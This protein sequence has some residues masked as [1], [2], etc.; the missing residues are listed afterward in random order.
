MILFGGTNQ[1]DRRSDAH[2]ICA[3][4]PALFMVEESAAS[5]IRWKEA[6]SSIAGIGRGDGCCSHACVITGRRRP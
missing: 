5:M 6:R 1:G 3:A 4:D 2:G